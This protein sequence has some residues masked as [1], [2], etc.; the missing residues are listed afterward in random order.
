MRRLAFSTAAALVWLL[1][2]GS[3]GFAIPFSY[4]FTGDLTEVD[5]ILM[6]SLNPGDIFSG[7][8]SFESTSA[9]L[10]SDPGRWVVTTPQSIWRRPRAAS[11]SRRLA[12][13]S[14]S[15][16]RPPGWTPCTRDM[17]LHPA[18]LEQR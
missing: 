18:S 13:T 3:V 10:V 5:P 4:T 6:L 11:V 8:Y 16:T 15:R 9:P 12:T 14:S 1:S 2:V 17:G 7:T